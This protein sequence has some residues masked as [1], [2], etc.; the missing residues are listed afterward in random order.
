[1]AFQNKSRLR[2]T[3]KKL[4]GLA[5]GDEDP[6][7]SA[8]EALDFLSMMVG[9]KP[10]ML[11]GRGYNEQ[12]WIKGVLQ[13]ASDSKLHIVE[14]PFWDASAD[15]GAGAALPGWYLDHTRAAFAE[16]RAW[17]ICR[18]RA[19]ADEVATICESEA[20]TVAQ[21]ARLLNYPECCVRAHYERGADYQGVWLDLLRRKAGGDEE[22]AIALLAGKQPLEP[23]T[24]ED[25][26]RLEVAMSTIPVPFTSINACNACVDGGPDA[27][28]NIKSLEGRKLAGDIDEGLLRALG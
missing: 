28:A 20:I 21:E 3:L 18:A 15:S 14:G 11:L 17:Y 25:L 24:D 4:S 16:H 19:V 5:L 13:I 27:P 7:P 8:Q 23:D 12:T 22:K 26:K 9:R 2:N 1:M 6:R 10:V